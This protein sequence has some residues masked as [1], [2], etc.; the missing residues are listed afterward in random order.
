MAKKAV[1]A[2]VVWVVLSTRVFAAQVCD[3][4]IP[5]PLWRTASGEKLERR[6]VPEEGI[7]P[8]RRVTGGR[9]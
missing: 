7:E 2:V 4:V 1:L 8:T 9:F 6:L 3:Y 5:T